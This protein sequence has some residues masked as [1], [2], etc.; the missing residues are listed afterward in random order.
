MRA[1]RAFRDRVDVQ[2]V[3]IDAASMF[4]S[5]AWSI[6][7]WILDV[8]RVWLVAQM[9]DVSLGPMQAASLSGVTVLGSLAPTVGGLG[10]VEGGLIA[11]LIAFGVPSQTAMAM[12]A[13]ERGISYGLSTVLGAGALAALGGRELW[14]AARAR[15]AAESAS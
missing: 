11:A 5:A 10:V 13:V 9:F 14:T 3:S 12:T 1:W 15:A 7:V 2:S 8:T 4:A 6:V